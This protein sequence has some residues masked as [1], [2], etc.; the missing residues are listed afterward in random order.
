VPAEFRTWNA[1][2]LMALLLANAGPAASDRAAKSVINASV[3]DVAQWLGD[4]PTVAR[5]SYL[6]GAGGHTGVFV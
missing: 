3:R 2:V 1:T 6:A 4:T 5:S